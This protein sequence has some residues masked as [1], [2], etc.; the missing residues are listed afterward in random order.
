MTGRRDGIIT[1]RDEVNLPGVTFSASQAQEAFAAKGF[2]L[3]EMVTLLGG[4][5]VGVAHCGIFLD[6]ISDFRGTRAPDSSM[7]P[8]L[9]AKLNVTCGASLRGKIQKKSPMHL[10]Q[11][12]FKTFNWINL[13]LVAKLKVTIDLT[14]DG[15]LH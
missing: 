12:S 8:S 14:G 5:I 15:N 1:V 11:F 6:C 9:V 2:N 13:N 7:D 4:H 10:Y 3:T